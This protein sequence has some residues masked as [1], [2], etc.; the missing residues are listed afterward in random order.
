MRCFMSFGSF[1]HIDSLSPGI[2]PSVKIMEDIV[3]THNELDQID[4]ALSELESANRFES[5]NRLESRSRVGNSVITYFSDNLT[6]S[7]LAHRNP[8]LESRSRI[9][10]RVITHFSDNLTLSDLAHDNQIEDKVQ[11]IQRLAD[12]L[13]NVCNVYKENVEYVIQQIKGFKEHPFPA[14]EEYRKKTESVWKQADEQKLFAEF[15]FER[16]LADEEITQLK[17]LNGLQTYLK[18]KICKIGQKIINVSS[19]ELQSKISDSLPNKDSQIIEHFFEQPSLRIFKKSSRLSSKQD[20]E[21][22]EPGKKSEQ[23]FESTTT[24]AALTTSQTSSSSKPPV[25]L[26]GV[27]H[28]T[29]S[30]IPTTFSSQSATVNVTVAY[31]VGFGNTLAVCSEPEWNKPVAF[32]THHG[33]EWTGQVPTEKES[34]FVILNKD[35]QISKWEQGQN[36]RFHAESAPVVLSSSQVKFG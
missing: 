11:I 32:I 29:I 34:K 6:L 8:E 15:E 10:N 9:G 33:D 28:P 23:V 20:V 31:N 14:F 7:D 5:A 18:K 4:W 19:P 3:C 12:K 2:P 17:Q 30:S 22:P 25:S 13:I 24:S 16:E 1:R 36:R 21:H 26:V 35:Y 27:L